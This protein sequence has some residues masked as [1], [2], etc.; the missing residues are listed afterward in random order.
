MVDSNPK[1][2][3]A[4]LLIHSEKHNIHWNMAHGHTD[5]M[6]AT[7]EQ[8]YHTASI[9]KTF[10]A[11]IIAMLVEERK[12][13]YS[14]PIAKYLTEDLMK[15]L[16]LYKGKDKLN[17]QGINLTDVWHDIPPVRHSK[18]KSRS[19][20]ELSIKLLERIITIA[21]N[22]GD[23]VFDPFG[24]SG[25]TYIMSEILERKWLGCEIG[26]IDTIIQRFKGHR[27]PQRID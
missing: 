7:A 24:G 17:I 11:M 15:D 22:K 6:P 4:Y 5:D 26:P 27:V 21:S 2:H 16:H 12:I 23:V 20:N 9:G 14:D 13:S 19:S 1:L 25:T 8:P 3:N 18:Y 10:T